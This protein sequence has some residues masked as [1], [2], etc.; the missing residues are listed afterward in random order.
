MSRRDTVPPASL[1]GDDAADIPTAASSL[2]RAVG[3]MAAAHIQSS[4]RSK[5]KTDRGAGRSRNDIRTSG[6]TE[7]ESTVERCPEADIRSP[8][9]ASLRF[10]SA[11][12]A[13]KAQHRVSNRWEINLPF[14]RVPRTGA[15]MRD[16]M[17]RFMKPKRR[18]L[19]DKRQTMPGIRWISHGPRRKR[20]IAR[21]KFL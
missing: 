15:A 12:A 3:Y 1:F 7:V 6:D 13:G 10:R 17:R 20:M 2:S 21:S 5:P 4:Q 9:A 11:D 19:V 18:A 8:L 14:V 16:H